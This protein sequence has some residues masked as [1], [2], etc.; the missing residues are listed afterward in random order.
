MTSA[1]N[2][3]M[4]IANAVAA[5]V[6]ANANVMYADRAMNAAIAAYTSQATKRPAQ[7]HRSAKSVTKC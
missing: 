1:K 6:V 4:Q 7:N 3:T 2:L 5:R